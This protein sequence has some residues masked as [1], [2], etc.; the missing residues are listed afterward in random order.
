VLTFS[1]GVA[2]SSCDFWAVVGGAGGGGSGVNSGALPFCSRVAFGAVAVR[3]GGWVDCGG[4][5]L[6]SCVAFCA[7]A[8][9][10]GRGAGAVDSSPF[11][12]C[13][14][15]EAV[16]CFEATCFAIWLTLADVG[17]GGA[18]GGGVSFEAFE[19]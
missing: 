6:C 4:L 16:G 18:G 3:V 9:G 2:F 5:P 17:D 13:S 19:A 11:P 14:R 1:S 15:V 10:V 8:V 12:F 7:V